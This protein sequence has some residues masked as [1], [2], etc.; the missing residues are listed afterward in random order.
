MSAARKFIQEHATT[1]YDDATSHIAWV[2]AEKVAQRIPS[3]DF[4]FP[5]GSRIRRDFA[6]GSVTACDP[7]AEPSKP[8]TSFFQKLRF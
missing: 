7:G 6:S 3:G 8:K 2:A 5:D 1:I 4:I